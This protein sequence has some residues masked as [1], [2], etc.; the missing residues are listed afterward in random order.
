MM[1]LEVRLI[2]PTLKLPMP[3]RNRAHQLARFKERDRN[4]HTTSHVLLPSRAELLTTK[5]SQTASV[6][7]PVRQLA[8]FMN[9]RLGSWGSAET[10]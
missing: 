8:V 9:I 1:L 6:A 4:K 5:H 2:R 3:L 10:T 7:Y